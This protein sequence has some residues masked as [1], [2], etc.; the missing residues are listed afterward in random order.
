MALY[1][2]VDPVDPDALRRLLVLRAPHRLL[3]SA[4]HIV[5]P[6]KYTWIALQR[7]HRAHAGDRVGD[8]TVKKV[9]GVS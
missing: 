5:R 1:V 7:R 3:A 9:Q 6:A 4:G 8:V 2:G